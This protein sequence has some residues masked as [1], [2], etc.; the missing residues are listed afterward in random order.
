MTRHAHLVGAWP[1]SGPERAMQ[2]A[3]RELGEHLVCMSDGETGDRSIWVTPIIDTLRANP[4]VEQVREG[5]GTSYEDT[6]E[7]RLKPGQSLDPANLRLQYAHAFQRSFDSFKA[8]RRQFDRP[9]LRFQVGIPA[10]TDLAVYSFGE[11]A[12]AD[13]SLYEAFLEAT[14]REIEEIVEAADEDVVFQVETVVGLVAVAQAD[15]GEQEAVANRMADQLLNVVRRAPK[16]THFG[17]HLCLGDFNHEAYGR[18]RDSRPLVLLSNALAASWPEDRKL[19]FIHVPFAAAK[20][21]PIA[22]VEFYEPLRDLDLPDD[23]RFIAGFLHESLD[24]KAHQELLER[25]EERVGHEVD[26][27]AACGLGRRKS[28]QEAFDA[29]RETSA[30]IASA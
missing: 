19:E 3:L 2:T 18:M 12:F 30:L 17:F 29:M 9:E 27:A 6:P 15:D 1:G 14:A 13:H 24:L 20:E 5:D 8:L 23:V 28:S 4:D 11:A 21:P 22:E 26:I 7:F 16:G 10:P 25:I